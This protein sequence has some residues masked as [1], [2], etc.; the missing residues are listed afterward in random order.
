MLEP[1][2]DQISLFEKNLAE[3]NQKYHTDGFREAGVWSIMSGSNSGKYAWVMG[4]LTYTDFDSDEMSK[5]HDADWNEKQLPFA[6]V[7]PKLNGGKPRMICPTHPK[8]LTQV[9]ISLAST[10]LNRD[11]AL[12]SGFRTWAS[13]DEKST[14]MKDFEEVHGEGTWGNFLKEY[15]ESYVS[16]E[17]ELSIFLPGLSGSKD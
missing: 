6:A 10:I 5:E 11:V 14:F 3:H 8:V 12:S 4:P 17:D 16:Y 9:K 2:L 1:K 7:F 15:R 13:L